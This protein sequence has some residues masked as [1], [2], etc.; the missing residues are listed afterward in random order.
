MTIKHSTLVM[1]AFG[2][3]VI[4]SS[5]KKEEVTPEQ[6]ELKTKDYSMRVCPRMVNEYMTMDS[7]IFR[8]DSPEDYYYYYTV[9]GKMD[10][11]Y[12]LPV[13]IDGQRSIYL[14]SLKTA[15][16]MD[17]VKELGAS[18]HHVF[19]SQKTGKTLYDLCFVSADYNGDYIVNA[20][21]T[22]TAKAKAKKKAR[23]KK[24]K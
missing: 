19:I 23:K 10:N 3:L 8:A 21:M 4:L 13:L 6:I 11:D 22:P 12:E 18:V 15:T 16:D 1:L 9:N 7:V 2:T 20:P 5:C 24:R 17:P 14:S